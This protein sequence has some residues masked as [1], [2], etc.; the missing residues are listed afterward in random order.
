V[1]YYGE[2]SVAKKVSPFAADFITELLDQKIRFEGWQSVLIVP[3][4]SSPRRARERGYTQAAL[5]AEAIATYIPDITYDDTLL[6]RE[7]RTSQVHVPRSKRKSNMSNAFYA[8]GRAS[9][10]CIILID[11]TLIDARRALLSAG[12]RDVIAVAI[13]H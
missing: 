6:S 10:H 11:A 1:K 12:A 5:F 7:E 8:S 4:P 3:I 2:R 9:G 13:A